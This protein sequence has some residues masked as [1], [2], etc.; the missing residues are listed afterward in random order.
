MEQTVYN[1]LFLCTHNSARSIMAET[2]LNNLAV[3]KGRFKA[4]SAGIHPVEQINLFALEQ[5]RSAGLPSFGLQSKN[6]NEFTA[7]DAPR[8]H[9]VFTVDDEIAADQQPNWPGNPITAHW[10]VADPAAIEGTD[11]EKRRAF[12]QTFIYLYNRINIFASLPLANMDRI[13]LQRRLDE[14]GADGN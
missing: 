12:S 5:I 14:I 13:G 3:G 4:Y 7:P 1:V 6:W 8:M 11:S 2:I 9:F 10:R